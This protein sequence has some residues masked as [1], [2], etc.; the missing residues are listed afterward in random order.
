MGIAPDV[1]PLAGR[2]PSYLARE[3]FDIQQGIRNGSNS[4]IALMRMVVEKLTP[5]D[6]INITAYLASLPLS[7]S[8][9]PA[10]PTG[11]P[12]TSQPSQAKPAGG[13]VASLQTR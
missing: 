12:I 3:I 9:K 1:P 13:P 10:P 8:G 7:P 2:S 5:E 4:N 11:E 6:I